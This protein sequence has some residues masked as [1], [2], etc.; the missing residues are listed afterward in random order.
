M[1]ECQFYCPSA[2]KVLNEGNGTEIVGRDFGMS[3][4][5]AV[6]DKDW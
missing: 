3:A 5:V 2:M 4:I 1:V 6:M